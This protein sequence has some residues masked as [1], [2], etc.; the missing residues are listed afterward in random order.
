MSTA[1]KDNYNTSFYNTFCQALETA[2]PHIDT[3]TFHNAIFNDYFETA[4]LKARMTHT[5]VVLRNYLSSDFKIACKEIT[6][7]VNALKELGIGENFEYMFLPEYISTYGIDHYEDAVDTLAII[8]SFTSAEF[9][10]RPFIIK[11]PEKMIDTMTVWSKSPDSKIRR[12]ASEGSRPRLPWAMALPKFKSDPNPVLHILENLK[13]DSDEVVRRS[14]ANHLTDIAK[15]NPNITVRLAKKWYGSNLNVNALVKHACRT[16]F[17]EGNAEILSLFG[18]SSNH[19]DLVGFKL[20]ENEV[21]MGNRLNFNFTIE[22][23]SN[24]PRTIRIEYVIYLL[25]K[26]GSH[27]RKVFKISERDI[28]GAQHIEMTRSHHF[29]PITTRVYHAG[30]HKVAV[31]VNGKEFASKAFQLLA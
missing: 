19:L 4:E 18:L 12:L 9:A 17:K 24:D 8:T 3:S 7:T 11:Y 2:N 30:M 29:K 6:A 25:K 5:S 28:I 31:I 20:D 14:V 15:D 16:L 23:S 13:N 21:T 1:L 10:V 27:S 26:N 22:N